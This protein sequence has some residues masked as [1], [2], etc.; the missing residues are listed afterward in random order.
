[1]KRSELARLLLVTAGLAG[2][3]H[4]LV[5][6]GVFTIDE[7]NYLASLLALRQGSFS[8][9]ET[10]GLPPSRELIFFDP[11]LAQKPVSATPVTPVV[12]P[13]YAFLA[14][15]FAWLG[16]SGL[17]TLNILAYLAAGGLV[18]LF[19]R[20]LRPEPLA[21]WLGLCAFW[22][23][24]LLIEYALGVW[25]HALS[26]CLCFAAV[27]L[28]M[29]VR[30]NGRA[31]TA[32]AAGLLAGL[33][34]GV[35]YQNI[36][37]AGAVGLGLLLWSNRRWRSTLAYAAGLLLPLVASASINRVR[38]GVSNPVSKGATYLA[39]PLLTAASKTEASSPWVDGWLALV[40]RVVD[41]SWLPFS[42]TWASMG[43][44]YDARTGAFLGITA[45]RKALLQ[46]APWVALSLA[47]LLLA[48]RRRLPDEDAR[49]RTELRALSLPVLAMFGVFFAAGTRRLEGATANSRYLLE[50][51]PLAAA[52]LPLV[53]PGT[54]RLRGL[55]AGA[56]A[57][58]GL[59]LATLQGDPLNWP[60]QIV[61]LKAPLLLAAACLALYV[62]VHRTRRGATAFALLLGASLAW[63]FAVHV[64]DDLVATRRVRAGNHSQAQYADLVL[65]TEP[66]A[67]LAAHPAA[68]APLKLER[69]L[70]LVSLAADQGADS[71]R[72]VDALLAKGR[73]V[74]FF[75][76]MTP[77]DH[78]RRLLAG[79]NVRFAGPPG[80][81]FLEIVAGEARPEPLVAP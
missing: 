56:V 36:V 16:W 64:G 54:I 41:F 77:D 71:L 37:F 61:L 7:N 19:V 26:V 70:V 6:P 25:P 3:L 42:Q 39:T 2:L 15:P 17:F 30:E 65:P 24:G 12:P 73:R 1:M 20:R 18:F 75:Y 57:A 13:L 62:V 68:F 10:A 14:Y 33:A 23:A 59:A 79:R 32:L 81:P 43:F 4:V 21:A 55:V 49:L 72:L 29:R 28:A 60:R 78:R 58:G 63:A 66:S 69:D 45:V 50:L 5:L 22:F 74:F 31:A 8:L 9:Q 11:W 67:L 27:Y 38:L 80:S 47:G 46:S 34:T 35:R 44:S 52:A 40:T 51:V 53:L 48:W 76:P